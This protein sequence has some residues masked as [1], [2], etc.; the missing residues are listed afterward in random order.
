MNYKEATIQLARMGSRLA[1]SDKKLAALVMCT[2]SAV[3]A[4]RA[5]KREMKPVYAS[6][7]LAFCLSQTEADFKLA[8]FIETLSED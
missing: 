1:G 3:Y 5:G 4:W 8:R 2:A 7:I 6:A